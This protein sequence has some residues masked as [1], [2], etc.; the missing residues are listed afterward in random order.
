MESGEKLQL[1]FDS[2][3]ININIRFRSYDINDYYNSYRRDTA[4]IRV[5]HYN[6]PTVLPKLISLR[7]HHGGISSPIQFH[8]GRTTVALMSW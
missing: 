1:V 6:R 7:Q 2:R 4:L 8:I 5:C 3:D